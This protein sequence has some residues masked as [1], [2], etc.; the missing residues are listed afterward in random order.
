MFNLHY[1]LLLF[2]AKMFEFVNVM[3]KVLTVPFFQTR[4]RL[5]LDR[6]VELELY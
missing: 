2:L 5:A 4:C 1:F 3:S 6:H